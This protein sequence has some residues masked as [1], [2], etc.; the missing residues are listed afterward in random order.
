MKHGASE[1]GSDDVIKDDS[2]M[3][4]VELILGLIMGLLR[5]IILAKRRVQEFYKV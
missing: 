4:K 3:M 5:S 2:I 1:H